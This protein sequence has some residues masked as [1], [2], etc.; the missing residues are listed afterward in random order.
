MDYCHING[1]QYI[2]RILWVPNELCTGRATT[3][4]PFSNENE[5][6]RIAL[7]SICLTQVANSE[8]ASNGEAGQRR[9]EHFLETMFEVNVRK[10]KTC[11]KI[12]ALPL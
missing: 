9:I 8:V 3:T 5:T 1:H 11:C 6:T 2:D 7:L 4:A 12:Y 10:Y